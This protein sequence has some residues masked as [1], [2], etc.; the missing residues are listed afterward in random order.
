MIDLRITSRLPEELVWKAQLDQWCAA[1]RLT[2]DLSLKEP[3]L[4]EGRKVFKGVSSIE[5]FLNE[6]KLFMDDRKDC[7]C[8]SWLDT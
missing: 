6:Y 8:D 5:Q 1:H 7:R 3:E 2:T 4:H